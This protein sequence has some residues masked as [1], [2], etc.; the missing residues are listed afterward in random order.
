M[1]TIDDVI[2]LFQDADQ[3]PRSLVSNLHALREGT[4]HTRAQAR[5]RRALEA[6]G[7]T[8]MAI[9]SPLEIRA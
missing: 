1:T 8:V 6:R 4:A 7:I 3:D 5:L 2:A 9:A